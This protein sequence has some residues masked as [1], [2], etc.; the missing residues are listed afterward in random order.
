MDSSATAVRLL[1]SGRT[2]VGLRPGLGLDRLYEV[3]FNHWND[4]LGKHITGGERVQYTRSLRRD[5]GQVSPTL[6]VGMNDPSITANGCGM[7]VADWVIV[8]G[9]N[10][11][12]SA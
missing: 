12:D 6:E 5:L 11:R 8:R 2:Q 7:V 10:Q 3:L 4:L 1:G 9:L